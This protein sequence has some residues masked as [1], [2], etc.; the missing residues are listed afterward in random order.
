MLGIFDSRVDINDEILFEKHAKKLSEVSFRCGEY[1]Y[2]FDYLASLCHLLSIKVSL[3]VRLRDAYR[4]GDK[5]ELKNLLPRIEECINRLSDFSTQYRKRWIIDNKPIGM[6]VGQLRLG[7]LKA[8]LEETRRVVI[9]YTNG[10]IDR[11]EELREKI[12]PL[13]KKEANPKSAIYFNN[14]NLNATNNVL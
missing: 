1:K 8:R 12:L 10:T 11:I 5:E 2:I 4:K 3:G 7:G 14:H 9:A 13:I 6:E